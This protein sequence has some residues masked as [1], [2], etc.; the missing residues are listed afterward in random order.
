MEKG[1]KKRH[2][3]FRN[4]PSYRAKLKKQAL[5]CIIYYNR[6]GPPIKIRMKRRRQGCRYARPRY[7]I[8]VRK[9]NAWIVIHEDLSED[10]A[11]EVLEDEM[12][13][14]DII[15]DHRNVEV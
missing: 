13:K 4:W 14:R 3:N 7:D 1:K 15:G 5:G 9:Y 10:V 6:E 2:W 12:V 11:L 8:E